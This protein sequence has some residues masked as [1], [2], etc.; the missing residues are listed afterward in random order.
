MKLIKFI[1]GSFKK[2]IYI[3]PILIAV[4]SAVMTWQPPINNVQYEINEIGYYNVRQTKARLA[5]EARKAEEAKK[6]EAEKTQPPLDQRASLESQPIITNSP[7][8]DQINQYRVSRG[9][10]A[11]A[12]SAELTA[13][14][15]AHSN[16]MANGYGH[17]HSG[18]SG[19]VIGYG[20]PSV[21]AA[22]GYE[23]VQAWINSPGHNAILTGNFTQVGYGYV[24]NGCE[25]HT[26]HFR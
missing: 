23:I 22:F 14:A 21:E 13:S 11:L 19:E 18:Y 4:T 7:V 9:L 2:D 12:V 6:K 1:I 26:A 17:N 3:L 8:I 24:N 25:W 16:R 10:G 15:Q 20:C 5:E